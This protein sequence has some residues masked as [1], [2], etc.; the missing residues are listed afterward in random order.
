MTQSAHE[1]AHHR[2]VLDYRRRLREGPDEVRR[3][4]LMGLLDEEVAKA[5][6]AGWL[7]APG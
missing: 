1:Y 7:T 4:L 6:A 5:K 2:N 3:K